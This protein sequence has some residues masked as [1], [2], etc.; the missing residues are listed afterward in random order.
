MYGQEIVHG[1]NQAQIQ[2][3]VTYNKQAFQQF[4]SQAHFGPCVFSLFMVNNPVFIH[5]K[6]KTILSKP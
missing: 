2:N 6:T 3:S 5:K 4:P 1:L